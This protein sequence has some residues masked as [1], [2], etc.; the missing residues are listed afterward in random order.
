MES[1]LEVALELAL[2]PERLGSGAIGEGGAKERERDTDVKNSKSWKKERKKERFY[3][4]PALFFFS[5][6]K[7]IGFGFKNIVQLFLLLFA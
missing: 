1:I 2:L 3:L 5:K 7:R 4:R 6:A